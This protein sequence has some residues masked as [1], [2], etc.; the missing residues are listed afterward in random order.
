LSFNGN[1]II[2]CGGGGAVLTGDVHLAQQAKHLTTTAKRP[3]SWAFDHDAVGYNYRLPNLNAAL[4]CAQLEQLP[5]RLEQKR[6]L[7]G[8]Y[9]AAFARLESVSVHTEPSGTCS[10]YWLNLLLMPDAGQRDLLLTA[11][12][13]EQILLRPFWTPLHLQ[14]MYADA[15]RMPLPQTETLFARGVCLPS[16]AALTSGELDSGELASGART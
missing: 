2:T 1:K 11:A 9:A 14:P 5:Q 7:A 15:P 16:S 6:R 3:H 10:N 13:E 4:G 12:H 8:R